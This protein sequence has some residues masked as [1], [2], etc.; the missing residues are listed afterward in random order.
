MFFQ[1]LNQFNKVVVK[2]VCQKQ[3]RFYAH[4]NNCVKGCIIFLF[5]YY[6]FLYLLRS[7]CCS[8]TSSGGDS[9][10]DPF[11]VEVNTGETG[12][13][14]LGATGGRTERNDSYLYRFF[15]FRYD[16]GAT[17]VT[18]VVFGKKIARK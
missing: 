3:F 16:Q 15:S 8:E 7:E 12:G 11:L 10:D 5:S 13:I 9:I 2:H 18:L 4:N 14:T 1:S 6:S 17:G